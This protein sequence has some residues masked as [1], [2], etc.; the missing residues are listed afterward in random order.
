MMARLFALAG[1]FCDPAF[2]EFV[3]RIYPNT[4]ANVLRA[5]PSIC[6]HTV[7]D[8]GDGGALTLMDRTTT[9]VSPSSSFIVSPPSTADASTSTQ[10]IAL[11]TPSCN[12]SSCAP[13]VAFKR[14]SNQA[15]AP[16]DASLVHLSAM[17]CLAAFEGAFSVHPQP[18]HIRNH[19]GHTV[20]FHM[21]QDLTPLTLTPFVQ[22]TSN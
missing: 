21:G 11:V 5:A 14:D 22:S 10:P 12:D 8:C 3:K 1:C 4:L 20:P 7:Q 17:G 2:A 15:L 13:A 6:K 9:V 18:S 16:C 19:R